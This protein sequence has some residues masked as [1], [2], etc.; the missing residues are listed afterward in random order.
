MVEE[1]GLKLYWF[2]E[3]GEATEKAISLIW[4]YFFKISYFSPSK[5]LLVFSYKYK[6]DTAEGTAFKYDGNNPL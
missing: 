4:F 5:N 2:D 1:S 6:L 3:V